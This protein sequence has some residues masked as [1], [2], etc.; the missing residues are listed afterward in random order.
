MSNQSD[1]S[2]VEKS[3]KWGPLIDFEDDSPNETHTARH[4]TPIRYN[5]LEMTPCSPAKTQELMASISE[6]KTM[7]IGVWKTE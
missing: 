6:L 1:D 7:V 4:S 2:G 5:M 3:E